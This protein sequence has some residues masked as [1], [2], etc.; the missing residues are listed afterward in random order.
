MAY[1]I[2]LYSEIGEY[3]PNS[4]LYVTTGGPVPSI[5]DCVIPIEDAELQQD[6]TK[7]KLMKSMVKDQFIREIGS[8]VK[9]G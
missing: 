5:F 9:S 7:I 4:A 6:Q 3:Q 2:N 8:D 1:L